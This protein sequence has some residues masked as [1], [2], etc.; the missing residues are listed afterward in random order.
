MTNDANDEKR[1]LLAEV[2]E[3][4]RIAKLLGTGVDTTALENTC[5]DLERELGA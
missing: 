5:S 2:R 4:I 1:L 3:D